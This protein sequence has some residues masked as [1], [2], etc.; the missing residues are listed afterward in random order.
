MTAAR[1]SRVL[2]T[3]PVVFTVCLLPFPAQA[4]YGGGT[5]KPNDPYQIWTPE[6]MNTI[7]A[8]PND[9]DKHFKLMADIGLS[10]Y[11]GEAFR[12]IGDFSG[13]GGGGPSFRGVFDGDAHTIANFTRSS[14]GDNHVGLFGAVSDPDAEIKNLRLLHPTLD[15][16]TGYA[17]GALVGWLGNGT[18]TNCHVEDGVVTG[19]SSVGGLAGDCEGTITEC[20]VT[21]V[22]T[23]T[24]CVGGLVG[25]GNATRCYAAATVTGG[26]YVGG[27]VG[28]QNFD[29]AADCYATGAVMGNQYVGGLMGHGRDIINCYAAGTVTGDSH[30]GGLMGYST[31]DVINSF[32]DMETSGQ[33]ASAGGEGKTTAE[34]QTAATFANWGACGDEGVWMLDEG[35]DYPRLGWE[36]KPGESLQ[37]LPLSGLLGGAGTAD[38]PFLIYTAEQLN[39]IGVF[40][41]AW[42]KQ[43]RLMADIDLSAYPRATFH[44]IG[45]SSTPFTGVLDGNGHAIRNFSYRGTDKDYVG[46]LGHVDDSNATIRNLGLID[47]NINGGTGR[48]V[49]S[50]V[51]YLGGG[52][53]TDCYARGSNVSG[54]ACTGGLVGGS[55]YGSVT[56]CYVSGRVAGG[57]ST[58][59]LL[60]YSGGTVAYCY[61][62]AAVTGDSKVGGLVAYDRGGVI[63]SFWD[64]ETSGQTTSAGGEGKTTAEMQTAATFVNWGACGSEGSW[65][66]YEGQDCPR[67]RWENKP[68]ESLRALPLSA[69]LEGDGTADN[70]YLIHTA[71]ELNLIGIFPCVWDEHFQLMA[72][73]DLSAYPGTTF[74]II[75]AFTIPFTGVLDGNEHVIANF[76]YT[77]ANKDCVG[78]LRCVAGSEAV[79]KN[80]GLIDPNIN[81]RTG[82]LVGSLVGLSNGAVVDCYVRG[83]AVSGDACVGGLVGENYY[84]ASITDC[85][86]TA[87]VRGGWGTGGLV[88]YSGHYTSIT[89][90]H[91]T[92]TATGDS[93]VGGLVGFH[94]DWGSLADCYATGAVTGRSSV[95]ALLG[96]NGRYASTTDCYATGTATGDSSVGGLA[97]NNGPYSSITDCYATGTVTGYNAIGGLAGHN[98]YGSIA[99][100]HASGSVTGNYDLGGLVG[101][102]GPDSSITGCYATGHVSGEDR[103]GGLVGEN[104]SGS[105]VTAS[106]WD[107]ETSG[108]ATSAGGA[109]KTTAEMQ[110]ASTFL[111]AGWDFMGKT[112]NGEEGIWWILEGQDYPRLWWELAPEE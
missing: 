53:L 91:A 3:I 72:D 7:G 33:A 80:L 39:L 43:F 101:N 63:N 35:R 1:H 100:C 37:V 83:G 94:E 86:A 47:P 44:I 41:C 104:G 21:G 5:G 77:S 78:L 32:W 48:Y 27:L 111:E 26:N 65:T 58:G 45:M 59:G 103:F 62:A 79:I 99:D 13:R 2:W 19:S 92:G 30:T 96:H 89:G 9:W 110:T 12:I 87:S 57:E 34:M 16:G 88:G 49:G 10:A 23:G 74:H 112:A 75:G 108:Q 54:G 102:N 71:E 50:M 67:L 98:H 52:T 95:G 60:G 76:T 90:C 14:T 97:G 81:A 18:V 69:F 84:Y 93:S 73:I 15:A 105:R 55:G 46:L 8:E 56:N 28:K 82:G 31:G 68:G 25:C 85:C 106:F 42:D 51:G 17:V 36:K 64:I 22:V 24:D 11:S 4:Q 109:G 38:N 66:L 6:Q 40:P 70:P 20:H 61:S 107:I 29:C